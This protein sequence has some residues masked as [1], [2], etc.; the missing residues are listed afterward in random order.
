MWRAGLSKLKFFMKIKE[1]SRK[2]TS[3]NNFFDSPALHCENAIW[4]IQIFASISLLFHNILQG[5]FEAKLKKRKW[6]W[7]FPPNFVWNKYTTGK[8]GL[9]W[10]SGSNLKLT[11]LHGD[12][13]I[14]HCL[15]S[16][17]KYTGQLYTHLCKAIYIRL[18]LIT[19]VWMQKLCWMIYIFLNVWKRSS[20]K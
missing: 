1:A 19:D 15:I 14:V 12:S 18:R 11:P 6:K 5:K 10:K 16:S 3:Q 2:K 4:N 8:W 13:C 7:H 9:R 20:E 17:H